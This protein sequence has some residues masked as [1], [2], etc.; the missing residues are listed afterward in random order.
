MLSHVYW[1][2]VQVFPLNDWIPHRLELTG[3]HPEPQSNN[4]PSSWAVIMEPA[5]FHMGFSS[6]KLI[7]TQL[8][9]LS[10][11][12]ADPKLTLLISPKW[13][14]VTVGQSPP[15]QV[16]ILSHKA[17]PQIR[18]KFLWWKTMEP[19]LIP[20][21]EGFL[22]VFYLPRCQGN[23]KLSLSE[24]GALGHSSDEKEHFPRLR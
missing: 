15:W 21:R 10:L 23:K 20:L 18:R 19:S 7:S 2:R 14:R 3:T 16:P 9:G 17:Y 6:C 1:E 13:I 5:P 12:S 4:K 11:P 24:A 22:G 8:L